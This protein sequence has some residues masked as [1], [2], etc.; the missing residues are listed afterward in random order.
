M[1]G[2]LSSVLQATSEGV[3][4]EESGGA[5]RGAAGVGGIGASPRHRAA[6]SYVLRWTSVKTRPLGERAAGWPDAECALARALEVPAEGGFGGFQNTD[7]LRSTFRLGSAVMAGTAV[8]AA[9]GTGERVTATD[10]S[11]E[12]K[13]GVSQRRLGRNRRA[14]IRDEGLANSSARG[15]RR[16]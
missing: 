8:A 4:Q 13:S 3:G 12:E 7:S 16:G 10:Q 9:G 11:I 1:R 5:G 14:R 2:R 15:S 6:E